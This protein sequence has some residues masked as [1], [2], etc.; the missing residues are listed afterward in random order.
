MVYL[1]AARMLCVY[2]ARVNMYVLNARVCVCIWF[3]LVVSRN[4][5]VPLASINAAAAALELYKANG[6]RSADG[7]GQLYNNVEHAYKPC[8]CVCF[9]MNKHHTFDTHTH[10]HELCY[11]S[12]KIVK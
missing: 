10:A 9:S 11:A 12:P 6:K 4:P 7:K 3:M 5:K 1:C 2:T 8:D